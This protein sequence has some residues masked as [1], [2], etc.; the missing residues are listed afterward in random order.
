DEKRAIDVAR[1]AVLKHRIVFV[2]SAGN[3]GPALSTS[4]APG[5]T[6]PALLSVG[7]Y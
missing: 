3:S 2:S 7:A 1:E 4:G 5:A 6:T